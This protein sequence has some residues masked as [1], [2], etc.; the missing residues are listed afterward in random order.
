MAEAVFV[1]YLAQQDLHATVISRGLAAPVGRSPHSYAIDVSRENG[2]PISSEK[3]AASVSGPEM[4]MA[5]AIFVMDVGHRHE[6]QLRF[7]TSTGKTFL[8]GQWQSEEIE[9]PINKS[10]ADFR[11]VWQQINQGCSSW[12]EKLKEAG[13]IRSNCTA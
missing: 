2:I 4:A 1:H 13:V 5:K 11:S 6:I 8:L 9:D 10:L 12:V 7:P 3:R